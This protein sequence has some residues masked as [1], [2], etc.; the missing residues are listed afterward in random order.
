MTSFL[1]EWTAVTESSSA[2]GPGKTSGLAHCTGLS[3]DG[4]LCA[5]QPLANLVPELGPWEEVEKG[6]SCRGWPCWHVVSVHT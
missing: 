5:G 1:N 3:I 4:A 2:A 6:A